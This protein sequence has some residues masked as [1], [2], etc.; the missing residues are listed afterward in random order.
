MGCCGEEDA[1]LCRDIELLN[2]VL[3]EGGMIGLT[4]V[5]Q[6]RETEGEASWL[7]LG[8]MEPPISP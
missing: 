7:A 1:H 3:S 2:A 6:K 4:P 8:C 5:L